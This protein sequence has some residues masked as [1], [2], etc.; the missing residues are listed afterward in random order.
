M[1]GEQSLSIA[2]GSPPPP[3]TIFVG[4]EHFRYK[5]SLPAED[6]HLYSCWFCGLQ[7]CKRIKLKWWDGGLFSSTQEWLQTRVTTWW[8]PAFLQHHYKQQHFL[9]CK[10]DITNMFQTL[11][12]RTCTYVL[13]VTAALK[14]LWTCVSTPPPRPSRTSYILCIQLLQTYY[15]VYINYIY[16]FT[17]DFFQLRTSDK[18]YNVR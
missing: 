8:L 3:K 9:S 12:I 11:D 18:I 10:S 5:I 14:R 16:N 7:K 1:S 13:C 17:P 6:H 2:K 15:K 4:P